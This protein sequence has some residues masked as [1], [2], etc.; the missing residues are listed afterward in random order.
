MSNIHRETIRTLSVMIMDVRGIVSNIHEVTD[1]EQEKIIA[2]I[3][4]VAGWDIDKV[5]KFMKS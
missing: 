1:E 4:R 3:I 5:I 2:D